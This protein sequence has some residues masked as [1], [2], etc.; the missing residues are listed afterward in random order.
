MSERNKYRENIKSLLDK[1]NADFEKLKGLQKDSEGALKD[2][3]HGLE[4]SW[5]AF[6]KG[7]E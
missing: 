1:W 4:N 3:K 2:L 5:N 6:D 7:L